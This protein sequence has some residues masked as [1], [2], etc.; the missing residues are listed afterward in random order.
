MTIIRSASLDRN[1]VINTL[2]LNRN[3]HLAIGAFATLHHQYLV[4][5]FTGMFTAI[6]KHLSS[7]ISDFCQ[8]L[9]FPAIDMGGSPFS[10]LSKGFFSL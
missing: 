9:V 5:I 3:N 8:P 6:P 4:N 7:A 10:V 2:V 1:D